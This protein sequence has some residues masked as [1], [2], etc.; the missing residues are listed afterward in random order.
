MSLQPEAAQ[1]AVYGRGVAG[2]AFDVGGTGTAAGKNGDEMDAVGNPLYDR[3]R[4]VCGDTI[5]DVARL[6]FSSVDE[7]VLIGSVELEIVVRLREDIARLEA[8]LEE[9]GQASLKQLEETRLLTRLLVRKE[10]EEELERRLTDD[11]TMVRRAC[12]EF[13][14][15]RTRYF[16]AVE[17]QVVKLALAIAG[18]VLYREAK[19][20]PLLLSAAVRVALD[21]VKDES[22]TRLRVPMAEVGSWSAA[23]E[24]GSADEPGRAVGG[25]QVVGDM[26]LP[27]GECVIE[28]SVGT[29]ELGIEAQLLEI[30][31]GFF[32]LL[33]KRPA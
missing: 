16:A 8:R 14:R 32:D 25:V 6:E 9:Q 33:K 3:V 15:E 11:R 1:R 23:F 29:V 27:R 30:E 21:K 24:T 19:M 17:G 26:D 10:W 22:G 12:E 2:Q 4:E 7:D 18:R 31:Q 20:D 28:T 5:R 13:D